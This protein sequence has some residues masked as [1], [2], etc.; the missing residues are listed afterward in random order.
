MHFCQKFSFGLSHFWLKVLDIMWPLTLFYWS[1]EI[2][3][4]VKY[5]FSLRMILAGI[6]LQWLNTP[7]D[8]SSSLPNTGV[9]SQHENYIGQ[10]HRVYQGFSG[11]WKLSNSTSI[12]INTNWINEEFDQYIFVELD[13]C[14]FIELWAMQ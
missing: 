4:S 2:P 11:F 13:L 3:T 5:C 12:T 6:V 14:M 10:Y 1:R 7:P 9:P 8:T